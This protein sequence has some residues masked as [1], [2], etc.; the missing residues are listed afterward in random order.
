MKLLKNTGIFFIML[1]ALPSCN[2]KSLQEKQSTGIIEPLGEVSKTV[3]IDKGTVESNEVTEGSGIEA[4]SKNPGVFWTFNDSGGENKIYA[5]STTGK[6]L[7]SFR[8]KGTTNVDWEDISIG[9]GPSDGEYYIY[10]GDIGDNGHN[11]DYKTIYRV[12]EPVVDSSQAVKYTVLGGVEKYVFWYSSGAKYNAEA[13]MVDPLTNDI[14]VVI[15][16]KKTKVFKANDPGAFRKLSEKSSE[17]MK[18]VGTLNFRSKANAADISDNGSEILI[19]DDD[20]VY[21]W[22]R[23]GNEPVEKTLSNSPEVLPYIKEPNGEGICW[24][25][26]AS[27][28]YTFSE[29]RHAHLYFY[30]RQIIDENK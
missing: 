16:D 7:G 4:S 2:S 1:W 15:K 14:F 27:G 25:P 24:A 13:L 5:F 23:N 22:H 17:K 30:P 6:N 10:V 18:I 8:L 28:Y 3:R 12:L 9:P 29:G 26:D 20:F 21:Y 11:R 19:K